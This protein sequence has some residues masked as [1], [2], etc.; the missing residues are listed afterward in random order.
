MLHLGRFNYIAAASLVMA[1][2]SYLWL[3]FGVATNTSAPSTEEIGELASLQPSPPTKGVYRKVPQKMVMPA[4]PVKV[5]ILEDLARRW[6]EA[7]KDFMGEKLLERHKE[8]TMEAVAKLGP[9]DELL[10]FLEFLAEKGAGD[11]RD[12]IIESGMAGLFTGPTAKAA[13][14]WLHTVEDQKLREKLCFHAGENYV[15]LGLKEYLASFEPDDHCQS[16]VL[17]GY[18]CHQAKTDPD[19][20][21]KAFFDLRPPKVD[22]SGLAQIMA[23]L[24]PTA[25]FAKLSTI[26]PD[27]SKSLARNARTAL[28]QSW[29][30]CRPQE[31]AQYVIANTKLAAP[32]QMATV[33]T[34]WAATAPDAAANWVDSLSAGLPRDEGIAALAKF[35]CPTDIAKAWQFAGQVGDFKKR[36]DTA[37]VVFKEWEKTDKTA[38]TAAWVALF[39]GK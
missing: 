35:W 9:S 8:L 10:R 6:D 21:V 26:L 22:V 17:S 27:D 16:A 20:A 14:D 39:P 12:W 32:A 15:G 2:G 31:A 28:L 36:V 37:T 5:P 18:C 34:V 1:G 7:A 33:L 30:A 24:P 29:S 13:R 4:D 25:N 38:A 19:G 3:R 11:M 23:V